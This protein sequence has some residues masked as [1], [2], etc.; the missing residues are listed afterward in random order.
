M[1]KLFSDKKRPVHMGRFPTE[2][3][4]RIHYIPDLSK[5]TP[6]PNLS[7][8]RPKGSTSIVPAMAEF[9][10]MMDAVRDGSVNSV[11]SEIP[12]DIR[13]RANHLKAFAYFNDMSVVGIGPVTI[14]DHLEKTRINPEIDR[15]SQALSTR[16]TKTLAAGIDLI[17]ADLKEAM[18]AKSEPITDHHTALVFLVDYRRDPKP[19]ELGCDWVQDVQEERAAL[20]GNETA[21]VIANY[22]RVLGYSARS[23]SATTTDVDLARLPV[24][25]GV[26]QISGDRI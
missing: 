23:H 24:K 10:A 19:E 17:M 4:A 14:C 22:I 25:S 21:S 7:F 5:L 11:P 26:V 6:W 20:L 1:V 9:Q 12:N 18:A 8:Q 13:E 2:R 15:L 16:Q 3:L